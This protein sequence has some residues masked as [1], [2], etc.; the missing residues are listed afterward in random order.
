MGP[1][2]CGR[3]SPPRYD[4]DAGH[5]EEFGVDSLEPDAEKPHALAVSTAVQAKGVSSKACV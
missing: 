5:G 3:C 1:K 2:H 4:P